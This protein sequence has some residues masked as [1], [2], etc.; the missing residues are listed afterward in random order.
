MVRRRL[1]GGMAVLTVDSGP[2][3]G[4]PLVP[5]SYTT[6]PPRPASTELYASS[7]PATPVMTPLPWSVWMNP[8]KGAARSPAGEERWDVGVRPTPPRARLLIASAGGATHPALRL[9]HNP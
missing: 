8:S 6:V 1:G 5:F 2:G 4:S 9:T 7:R 3:M